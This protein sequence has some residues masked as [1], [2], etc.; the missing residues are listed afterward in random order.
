M[1]PLLLLT[2]FLLSTLIFAQPTHNQ[3]SNI[4]V[5]HIS[6]LEIPKTYPQ[7]Q[8]VH[9]FAYTLSYSE[10][11]EQA[12][13]VAYLLTREHVSN[14]VAKRT[15]K[16]IIDPMVS[17]GS[18]TNADY[19]K[20][21]YDRGHFAPAGDMSW[22]TITMAES[23]YY[24]NMSPQVPAFNRGIWNRLEAKV[25]EWAVE[26]DSLYI[27]V[28]GVLKGDLPT[29]GVDKVSVPKYF[30]K[31]VLKYSKGDVKGI[32]FIIPNTGS[33]EPLQDFVCTIDSVEVLTGIDFYPL[34]PDDEEKAIEGK[35]CLGCW[36]WR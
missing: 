23:F 25:R 11:N 36:D 26:Y 31:V 2:L 9:H 18:A 3:T 8:I 27:A 15:N 12:L 6:N 17:T 19:S 24:S 10:P 14:K 5:H 7:D 1:K 28:G 13:W 35:V 30:Y 20:S 34:L 22:S 29:I 4:S 16:F 32:G 21:G 33:S